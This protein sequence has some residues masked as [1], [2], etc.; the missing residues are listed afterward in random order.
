MASGHPISADESTAQS[1]ALGERILSETNLLREIEH[2]ISELT[3]QIKAVEKLM[4]YK[5]T[6]MVKAVMLSLEEAHSRYIR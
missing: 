2:L 6:S 4:K 3:G 5:D 1:A